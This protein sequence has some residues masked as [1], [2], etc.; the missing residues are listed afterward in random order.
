ML[1][2]VFQNLSEDNIDDA[3]LA[4]SPEEM[5]ND[6]FFRRG[7]DFRKKWMFRLYKTVGSCCKIA[8]FKN[9]PVGMVQFNPLHRI[10]S[11]ATTRRQALYIHC[12]F[13]KKAF[14]E[15]GIGAKLLQKLIDDVKKPSPY[16][17]GQPCQVLVTTARQRQ[18][19]RQPSYFK[20][21]GFQE[22]EGNIDAGLVYWLSNEKAR[23]SIDV[24][25]STPIQVD[26]KGVKIFYDPCC[27]WCIFINETTKKRVNEIKPNTPI[28]EFDI[29]K[30]SKEALRRGITSRTT[31]V[32]GRPIQYK[33]SEQFREDLRKAL[34]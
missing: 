9:V 29:W 33:N 20:L 12:I 4:C 18:A 23:K 10:P 7:L 17:E 21:R 8:Y 2:V 27:Q 19:F 13:V 26:E 3:L 15:R 32:N 25:V 14:R 6:P 34:S 24:G 16:F 11:F 30:N 22:I 1:K 5:L 28:E 31:Y